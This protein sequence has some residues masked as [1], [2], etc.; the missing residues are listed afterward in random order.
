MAAAAAVATAR[1]SLTRRPRRNRRTDAI[2][3]AVRET[4]LS[5][6]NLVL[7]VFV[8]EGDAAPEPVTSMPGV[9]R[10]NL[11][12]TIA[13]AQR[14]WS[15]G[16]RSMAIFPASVSAELKSADGSEAWNPEGLVQRT[17]RGLHL[18]LPGLTV[19]TDVALDPY[20]T[21]GHDG[22]MGSTPHGDDL[23]ND[24]TVEALVRQ[25]L[26]QAEAGTDMVAPSDMMDGRIG[27]IRRA[28]DDAGHEDVGIL[29]YCAKYAS[30]FYGPFRDAV[31]SASAAGTRKLDKRTYQM[32]PAN[33]RE[34][35]A[36]VALDEAEGADA[37]MVKPAGPYLDVIRDVRAATTL[38]VAAYQVSGEYAMLAAA[39]EK[40]WLDFEAAAMESLLGIRRAG[41]D[42]ILTYFAVR[43]AELL[44]AEAAERAPGALVMSG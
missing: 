12:D 25:A 11:A 29:S 36:E 3:S 17:V 33:R 13:L 37:V 18:A 5:A 31:G 10:L 4:S 22:I 27:A 30:C 14:A 15:L 35:M 20:T 44:A 32:D 39:G 34:A 40:G 9:E 41:A 28:L 26:S 42:I 38:P 16:V 43:A 23:L 7:P 21:T 8:L 1:L 19:I 24:V 2:R 6:S